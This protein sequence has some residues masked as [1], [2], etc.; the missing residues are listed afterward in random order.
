MCPGGAHPDGSFTHGL[1][2]DS[3]RGLEE[4]PFSSSPQFTVDV[5][6]DIPS[7]TSLSMTVNAQEPYHFAEKK[8]SDM[9]FVTPP[10]PQTPSQSSTVDQTKRGGRNQCPQ[11]K[12]LQLLKPSNLSSLSPPPD[13]DSSPSRTSTCKKAPGTTPCN[14]KH[15]LTSKQNNPAN[16]SNLKTSK[17]RPPSGSFK[18]KQISSPQVEPQNFQ[19]KTSI[20]RPLA[21]PKELHAPHSS[22][23]SGDCVAS[24]RYSRLPKPKIH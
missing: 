2:Q 1:Q 18:Q 3:S 20:P 21:R 4:R 24:N 23:H 9:Q 7:E 19:A 10:P 16:H 13:S 15:Q 17:L 8:P 5:V 6:K 12:S 14:S 22:L 11:P